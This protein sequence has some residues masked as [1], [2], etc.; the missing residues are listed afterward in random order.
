M[1]ETVKLMMAW[2]C[3]HNRRCA[4]A[5]LVYSVIQHIKGG[6]CYDAKPGSNLTTPFIQDSFLKK[7]IL[8]KS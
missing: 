2:L 6:V 7:Y 5:Y 8:R 1:T 4:I 3:C